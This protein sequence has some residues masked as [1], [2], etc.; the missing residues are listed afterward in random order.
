MSVKDQQQLH[1]TYS[2]LDA[3]RIFGELDTAQ[4]LQTNF[5]SLY[6][7][8]SEELLSSVAPYL[9][10]Y[11][12]NSEFGSWLLEK[13][14]GNSWGIFVS[15]STSMEE[16]RKHFRK[17]LMVQTEDGKEL[18]FRF[19]DPRVLRIFLPTCDAQQ[20]QEF[21]G[22]VEHYV[23][24]DEDQEYALLFS[25]DGKKLIRERI[26]KKDFN[27]FLDKGGV[28]LSQRIKPTASLE[29]EDEQRSDDNRY[30]GWNFLS[31]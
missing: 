30:K 31:D 13:G 28:K 16:L 21:F 15:T 29:N 17:F 10:P 3:A 18:Y 5:L 14:W 23:M 22:P 2:I 11:E 8:Q 9:F 20:L 27:D 6:M 25:F 1:F 24:E 26:S 12:L 7:G 4:Q 19:Y